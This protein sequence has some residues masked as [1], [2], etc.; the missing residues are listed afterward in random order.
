MLFLVRQQTTARFDCADHVRVHTQGT[1]LYEAP[2]EGSPWRSTK[3][4]TRPPSSMPP[5]GQQQQQQAQQQAGAQATQAQQQARGGGAALAAVHAGAAAEGASAE[6]AAAVAEGVKRLAAFVGDF[7][8]QAR[9]RLSKL[10]RS[11]SALE[12]QAGLLEAQLEAMGDT[13]AKGRM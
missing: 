2:R 10:E 3:A 9:G 12:R 13:S 6:F 4:A 8:A 5:P 1:R 7:E 11:L